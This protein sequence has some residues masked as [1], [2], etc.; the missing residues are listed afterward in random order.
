MKTVKFLS[1]IMAIMFFISTSAQSQ[2]VKKPVNYSYWSISPV[3]GIGFPM[4]A[5]ADNFKSGLTFG[6]DISYKVNKEVGLYTKIGYYI[7]PSKIAGVSDGKF[8]EYTAGPRYYFMSKNLKS[9]LFFEVGL[10]GY[11]YMQDAYNLTVNNV[12]TPVPE[13]SKTN[14]GVNAGMG[15]NLNLGKSVDLIIKVKYHDVFTSDGSTS[16]LAP[17]LGIDIRL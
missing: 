13:N 12:E 9:S 8:L 3:A 2:T 10:G 17:L 1:V 14:F 6:V 7:F 4:G 15:A 16:F 11:S 5:F